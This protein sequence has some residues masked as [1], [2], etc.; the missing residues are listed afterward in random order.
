MKKIPYGIANYEKIKTQNYYF[1]DKTQF[2]EKLESLGSQYLF[3]LRPRRFGKSLFISILEHYYDI[4]RKDQ[5]KELFGDTYI[6]ENPTELR[7]SFLILKLNF[8]GIPVG[9]SLDE[10]EKLFNLSIKDQINYFLKKYEGLH[11]GFREIAVRLSDRDNASS[12]LGGLIWEL[13]QAGISYYLLID[14]YDNFA[15]NILIEHGRGTYKQITHA[16]GFLRSFFAVIKNGT[17]NR[18][19]EKLFVTG[20]SPFVLSDV[21]SGMNIGR[22]I[23]LLPEFCTMIGLMEEEVEDLVDYY[24][25]EGAIAKED[26]DNMLVTLRESSNNYRFGDSKKTLYDTDMVLYIV[27]EYISRQKIPEDLVDPNIRTDYGKLRF[28][29]I[30][31]R[32]LNGNFNILQQIVDKEEISA[33]LVDSFAIEEIVTNEKFISLLYYLGLLTIKE[34]YEGG[35]YNFTIPNNSVRMLLWEY[36]RRAVEEA[37]PDLRIDTVKLGELFRNMAYKGEWRPLFEFLFEE[38]YK[39]VANIRDFIWREEGVV[40]FLKT[41][42]ALSPLYIVEGE[43]EASGGYADIY[44]RKNWPVTRLTKYEYLIEIKYVRA[45]GRAP[46]QNPKDIQDDV[47]RGPDSVEAYNHTPH[48][49][50]NINRIKTKA[51]T[52][53]EKYVSSHKFTHPSWGDPEQI[54]ELKKIVIIASSQKVELMEEIG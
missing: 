25:S 29:V 14:E 43:Y 51:I 5:F 11:P 31:S 48:H 30:E 26:R 24:V 41:Y 15:N 38:F 34:S 4:L 10:I 53:L 13:A 44:L 18:S 27:D 9:K 8:S 46:Q 2:I 37:F 16:G 42:L 1:V 21:T 36:M 35:Y 17:E 28:L 40:M 3:F 19:I 6:G 22:N 23:S 50:P 54:P 20:V 52:Q 12:L 32:R 7:N 39:A 47:G 49:L 33:A 45:H